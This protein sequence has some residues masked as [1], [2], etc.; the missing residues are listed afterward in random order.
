MKLQG[1]QPGL[2][3]FTVSEFSE[4]LAGVFRR[5]RVFKGLRIR[6]EVSEWRVQSNGNLYFTLKDSGAALSCFAFQSNAV[7]F[8]P[9]ADGDAIVAT[10]TIDVQMRRSTY[11][12]RV[13]AIEASGI[14]ALAA[15]VEALRK[16]LKF[17]GLFAGERKRPVPTLPRRLAIVSARGKG[18]DDALKRLGERAPQIAIDFVETR[19][20]GINAEAEIA[21]ALDRASALPVDAILLVR[22]G[23]SYEDLFPFNTEAVV[24][25]IVRAAH[26]V[27]TG[28]GHDADHHLADD[29]ADFSLPTPTA[30]AEYFTSSWERV[31]QAALHATARLNRAIGAVLAAATQRSD[32]AASGL[33]E[34]S[35]RVLLRAQRRASDAWR[36]LDQVSPGRRL[37]DR[38]AHFAGVVSRL[39]RWSGT[40]ILRWERARE[41]QVERL[42]RTAHALSVRHERAVEGARARLGGVDPLS[43]LQR[44]YAIVTLGGRALQDAKAVAVGER[45]VATLRHGSLGARVETVEDDE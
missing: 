26:P 1:A 34:A 4:R 44:G 18:Y 41:M 14:G 37:A 11:Q 40:A 29:V 5:V 7:C 8:G 21:A 2:P 31:T 10:G 36:R 20:Q 16:R 17:E 45:I 22:G 28:I 30:A 38:T 25:A 23:G 27:I 33:R 39:D 9:V 13:T 12:L 43:P 3:E 24:R 32:A 19:V 6:G 15:Q 42:E 35:G